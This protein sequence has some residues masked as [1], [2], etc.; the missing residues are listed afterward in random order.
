M[1]KSYVQL[2]AAIAKL[3]KE[4]AALREGEMTKVIGKIRESI[5]TYGLT[6]EHLFG[7]AAKA[8]KVAASKAVAAKAA[9]KG[10]GVAKYR[11][12][13]TGKTWTGF[14]K[15]PGWLGRDRDKFLIDQSGIVAEP[16]VQEAVAPVAAVAKKATRKARTVAAPA[17]KSIRAKKV[18]TA[19]VAVPATKAEEPIATKSVAKKAAT[20]KKSAPSK[21][22]APAKKASASRKAPKAAAKA[23]K[24]A[25]VKAV[26]S[27]AA[28]KTRRTRTAASTRA[29]ESTSASPETAA[30]AS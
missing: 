20:T 16:P 23:P 30:S 21:K 2:K 25:A 18:A 22:A 24:K 7:R 8:V 26:K 4:A 14:G 15:P 28:A 27:K 5:A 9:R 3:E 12:P 13:K 17:K 29:P 1:T 11:D 19:P 10:A 6:V